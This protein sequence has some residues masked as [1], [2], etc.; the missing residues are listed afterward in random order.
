MDCRTGQPKTLQAIARN[1]L[2]IYLGSTNICLPWITPDGKWHLLPHDLALLTPQLISLG[3]KPMKLTR[4]S[5]ARPNDYGVEFRTYRRR[6]HQHLA[7]EYCTRLLSHPRLPESYPMVKWPGL[8][9]QYEKD[10]RQ[11]EEKEAERRRLHR[12]YFGHETSSD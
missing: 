1:H 3:I 12:S 10:Q 5:W 8:R 11:K 2:L 7:I 6:R 9:I 4:L